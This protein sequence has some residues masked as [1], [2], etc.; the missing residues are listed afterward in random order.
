MPIKFLNNV[1]VD[2]SVLYVDTIND[3]VGIGT[4]SPDATLK[5]QGP[6]DTATISTS[7]T[8]AARINNGGAIS[9]WIGSNFYN[10][11]YVQSIQ[12][13]GSN[14]LKPLSLQ[15]LGGN[16][17]IG[18]TSPD[19]KLDIEGDEASL[20]IKDTTSGKAWDWQI[21]AG[22]MEFGE[23]NVANNR[24]VIKNGGNVGIGTTSPDV[25]LEVIAAS[26]TD[27]IIADFVNSTNA[28]GTTAAIKLSNADS[29]ACDVV[30]GANRVGANFGSDFFISL[31]DSVDGSNQE[32]FRVTEAGAVKFNAYNSTNNTG[33]PTYLLGTD[34]SGNIVKTNTVPGSGAGPYLPLSAGSSYPLTGALYLENSNTDVV[35]SGNTSGNFNIDN[36][37]GNIAFLANGSSVQSMTITSSLITI[38]EPTNFTNGNVGIGTTSPTAKLHI[39]SAE[40]DPGDLMFLHNS[41][42]AA[43][44]TIKF[45]DIAAGTSQFGRITYRHSDGQSQGGGASFHFTAEPDTVL[46]VG[47]NTNKG[48]IAVSSAGNVSEVDYGFKDDINTGIYRAAGDTIGLV[49]AGSER[50]RITSAGNVGIGTT[51]PDAKLN[52]TAG[53]NGAALLLEA[54]NSN[55]LWKNITFKTYVTESQ[56]ANFSAGSHIYTTSPGGATTWPF[57][58]YGALVIEGRDNANGGIALRT[59]TGNGQITRIAIK[60]S[61]NVG[62]GTTSPS[63]QLN[64]HKNALSPATL[65]LSNTVVGGNN[66]VVVAQIKANT[67]N[68]ELT[69]IE[70]QNSSDSH[71]NGNLLFYNR[72]G[73]TNT[74]A[75]SMRITGEGDVGIGTTSPGAKLEVRSG[76]GKQLRLSTGA[77]TYWELGRSTST[78]DFEITED[79]GDTYFLIDKYNGNVGIGTTSPSQKLH[80]SGN[81]RVTGAYYDSNNSPGTANQVLISTVTGTD[82]VDGSAIPGVPDG[83][84]TAGKI[85]MWQDSDTLTDSKITQTAGSETNYVDIDFANVEDLTITGDS[86]FSTFTVNAFDAVNFSNIENN[87]NVGSGDLSI[88][89]GDNSMSLGTTTANSDTLTVGYTS[90]R[91]IGSGNVGIGTTSPGAKLDVN[92]NIAINPDQKIQLS[93]SADSTHHIYHDAST[94]YDIINYSTGFQLEHYA[95]GMQ[96]TVKGSNGNV[97]IGTTS[98][99]EKLHVVGSALIEGSSTE[100]KV[101]GS[102]GYDTANIVMGNAAKSDIFSIDTRNDPGGNYTTLSFDSYQTTG[103]STIT[104]GDNYVNLGTAGSSRVTINSTGNVGIGTTDPAA[105]LHIHDEGGL[106]AIRLSGTASGA[107]NF[108][109]TQGVIGLNNAGFSIYDV[110]ATASRL[111]IDTSGNVGIGTTDPRVPLQVSSSA[112]DTDFLIEC[113]NTQARMS[114]NNTSTGDSQINFQLGNTSRFTMGVDNSDSD[115]FKI[116]G[117]AALGSSDRIVVDSTGNV[118][119][120]TTSPGA[121]LDVDGNFKLSDFTATAVAT[122]GS[123]SPNQNYQASSQDTLA[124]LAV[125]P[126]GN[127]VRGMQEGTWTFTAAQLNTSLGNTL[128]EAP[129]V[130]KAVIVYESSWMIKYNATGAINANQR[131]EIRQA[132]NTG[133]G[134]ITQLPGAKINEILSQGQ[135]MP[136]GGA[137]AYGFYSRDVP[138]DAGGRTFKTNTATTLHRNTNSTLPSGVQTISIKLRYRIYNANTF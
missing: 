60:E 12:D 63:S 100:L 83:S 26:P 92:G 137:S 74:F 88:A 111:V 21:H 27:G 46:V 127:V 122:S 123:L 2:S 129:G 87:F 22:Y 104:L 31:S 70:T 80:V 106:A 33:T 86:S 89:T 69:R 4:T 90:T 55:N 91:F 101:K 34:A 130:N 49:T 108:Q 28:G 42:N 17:G 48:R 1:A 114:I 125:D 93:G 8:P 64:V 103:T 6:S 3:R 44:A 135:S 134:P 73:Y 136:G 77:T 38:N 119:I 5:V 15:P 36:N 39:S 56:A 14:N 37:T 29:E 10:Y 67:V 109:I 133:I 112:V 19:A 81:A 126:S 43:G 98:P 13:D 59:G 24:L 76:V 11:G 61:G 50:M 115:K 30:L 58:E 99:S 25:K 121:K 124:D 132:S 117:G 120:A 9:L 131:Y 78:G 110:D 94:D 7:S 79:S 84:G 82:W 45:T 23:V 105:D 18:T 68:E 54:E 20:R 32:R 85:V 52:I 102:G 65:E 51:S 41:T 116:S 96:L 16:V 97:G 72:N 40:S 66:G 75:E 71:D 57:T 107:D 138:A 113:G 128:I 35:M 53:D 62:I 47:D 95:L 118:G